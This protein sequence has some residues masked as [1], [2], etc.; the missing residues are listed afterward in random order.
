MND[1][2]GAVLGWKHNNEPGIRTKNGEIIGW[3]V[4]L[5][6]LPTQQQIDTWTSEFEA[7]QQANNT[8]KQQV[9][10]TAQSTIGVL[11]TNLTN[12]QIQALFALVLF[13]KGAIA[14]D[15]TIKPLSEWFDPQ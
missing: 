2:L 5:G 13:E 14:N 1:N 6:S 9:K 15:G 11:I 12:N 4:S 8:L 10:T 3:P 7:E